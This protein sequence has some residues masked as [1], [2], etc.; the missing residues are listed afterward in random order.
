MVMVV[1]CGHDSSDGDFVQKWFWIAGDPGSPWVTD[2]LA[3]VERVNTCFFRWETP[4]GLPCLANVGQT[5]I[6][7]FACFTKYLHISRSPCWQIL[8]FAQIARLAMPVISFLESWRIRNKDP[9]IRG[10]QNPEILGPVMIKMLMMMSMMSRMIIMSMMMKLVMMMMMMVMMIWWRG[11]LEMR[12]LGGR[13]EGWIDSNL[14]QGHRLHISSLIMIIMIIMI[15]LLLDHHMPYNHNMMSRM[16]PYNHH[17]YEEVEENNNM[18]MM[19][20]IRPRY[21]RD[22]NIFSSQLLIW[23]LTLPLELWS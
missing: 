21:H 15:M 16:V 22:C 17:D 8:I 18:I 6:C 3:H 4:R 9:R 19:W 23:K 14:S 13:Q 11:T 10:I 5:F 2:P 20:W 1:V 12:W 7:I